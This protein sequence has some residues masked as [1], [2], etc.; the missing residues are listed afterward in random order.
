MVHG[1]FKQNIDYENKEYHICNVG[2]L[3]LLHAYLSKNVC[4]SSTIGCLNEVIQYSEF[5]T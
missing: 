3:T 5:N 1:L 4:M 2:M